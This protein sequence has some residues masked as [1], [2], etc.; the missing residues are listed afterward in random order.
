VNFQ[1]PVVPV[2]GFIEDTWWY[3]IAILIEDLTNVFLVLGT[4]P[5]AIREDN[6][7]GDQNCSVRENHGGWS[8]FVYYGVV[9]DGFIGEFYCFLLVFFQ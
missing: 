9:H 6:G 2:T 1:W 8:V 7:V 4:S 3:R 5:G